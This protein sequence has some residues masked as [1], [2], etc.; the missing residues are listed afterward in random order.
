V[1]VTNFEVVD[2][3]GAPNVAGQ[4]H[5]H[6][7]M[8]VE[9]P[10]EP[11]MPAVT[12][13]GTYVPTANTTYTWQNVSPGMHNFSVELVNNNHTPLQPPVTRTV[14]VNVNPTGTGTPTPEAT[15]TATTTPALNSTV[16]LVAQNL[17]FSQSEITVQAGALVTVN[18]NNMDTGI[19]HNFAVYTD[20][21]ASTPIFQGA[22]VTGP[23]TTTYTFT[24]PS[25]PGSYFFRCDVHPEM[26]G[27]FTVT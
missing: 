15:P 7:F 23:T 16:D 27:T 21:S 17:A 12:Q 5:L 25:A 24:A 8:D 26:T 11:G 19:P 13:P 10:T 1:N 4:G 9:P 18:F 14:T 3:L 22:I 2:A 6:Y 20:A